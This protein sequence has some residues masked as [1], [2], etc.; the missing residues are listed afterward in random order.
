MISKITADLRRDFAALPEKIQRQAREALKVFLANPQHPSLKFKKLPPH[1]DIY[2]V[3]ITADYRAI[4]KRKDEVI[5]WFF[6][7]SHADYDKVLARL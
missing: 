1:A 6:I 4:G 7:G 3:R 5:T 2:S